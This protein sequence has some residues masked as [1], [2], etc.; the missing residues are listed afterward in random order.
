[1]L[2][3]LVYQGLGNAVVYFKTASEAQAARSSLGTRDFRVEG[4]V[5]RGTVREVGN[6]VDFSIAQGGATIT[7]VNQGSPPQLFQPCIPVVLEGH[8]E[9]GTST[10]FSNQIMVKHGPVYSA[11]H[12]GR[13]TPDPVCAGQ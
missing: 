7:V 6:S 5:V 11:K 8:F 12:P 10:F 3:F 2:G 13:L 4:T 9:S 1:A